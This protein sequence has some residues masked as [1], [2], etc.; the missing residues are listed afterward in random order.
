MIVT[1]VYTKK[2]ESP[3]GTGVI[4][5]GIINVL[6]LKKNLNSIIFMRKIEIE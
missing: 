5:T 6:Y 4:R 1:M 2:W 3:T